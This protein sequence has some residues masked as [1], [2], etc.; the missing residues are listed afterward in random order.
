MQALQILSEEQFSELS[1]RAKAE[2]PVKSIG[3]L[4]RKLAADGYR[5]LFRALLIYGDIQH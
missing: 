4:A 1:G 2:L 5:Q 3:N